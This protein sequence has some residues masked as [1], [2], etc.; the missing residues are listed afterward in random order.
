ML[1]NYEK[2]YKNQPISCFYTILF[3]MIARI[4]FNF[5]QCMNTKSAV[6]LLLFSGFMSACSSESNT[7]ESTSEPSISESSIEEGEVNNGMGHYTD[8]NIE[9]A[10]D[11]YYTDREDPDLEGRGDIISDEFA[12]SGDNPP[13]EVSLYTELDQ[14]IENARSASLKYG[15]GLYA[16]M[17]PEYNT[18]A[19][20]ISD[21]EGEMTINDV[22]INNGQSCSLG[23]GW[24]EFLRYGEK[25][26]RK[27]SYC[28]MDQVRSM[29]ITT[30]IGDFEFDF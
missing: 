2:V 24:T 17:A 4:F 26:A 13:F 15:N 5:E 19:S 9:S 20:I 29:F 27:I 18:Y 23:N 6:L 25:T 30:S 10:E 21:Y 28:D 1:N 12:Y 16:D 3:G 22:V 11:Y 8:E 7:E 14:T